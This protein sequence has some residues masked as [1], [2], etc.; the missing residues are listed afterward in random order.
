M[1]ERTSDPAD[2]LEPP[3]RDATS[4][5]SSERAEPIDLLAPLFREE[6]LR[7]EGGEAPPM[8]LW[9]TIFG[10]V[11]F[12][13]Y[14]L[15]NYIGDFS[16]N[17]WLQA[18]ELAAVE[19]SGV[20][21]EVT[22]SGAQIYNSRCSNCHQN[23]GQGVA[24]VFPPLDGTDWVTGD[25]GRIVRILLHGM[26]GP[27]E[28]QGVTYNGVMPAWGNQLSDEEIA[29]VITHVRQSWS[30]D[31]SEV[32]ADEV[33]RVREATEGRTDPWTAEELNANRGIPGGEV[34][35]DTARMPMSN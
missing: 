23:N 2:G 21:A 28:V 5:S 6:P 17:P 9:M 1:S 15:G 24:G 10:V 16:P 7:P 25:K 20:A 13:T 29:A 32:V 8:W 34:A 3:E 11:L 33:Q 27:V 14:Y 26:Q 4:S 31:A 18:P 12:G 22:V 35:A 30:N 19:P